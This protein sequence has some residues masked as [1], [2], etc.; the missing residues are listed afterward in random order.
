MWGVCVCVCEG[1]V[2]VLCGGCVS[3]ECECVGVV[4]VW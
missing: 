4:C 3:G 2:V 1:G